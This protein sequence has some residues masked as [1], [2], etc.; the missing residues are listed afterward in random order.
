[1]KKGFTLIE[2]LVVVLIIGILAAIALPQYTRAVE[3]TRV[4]GLFPLVRAIEQAQVRYHLATGSYAKTFDELDI[5]MPAG[6]TKLTDAKIEYNNFLCFL[7]N[8]QSSY[9]SVYCNSIKTKVQI[10]K[11]YNGH[12]ICWAANGDLNAEKICQSI[13]GKSVKDTTSSGQASGYFI[14]KAS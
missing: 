7:T 14:V 12:F 1:M 11:Y 4:T 3:K 6:G 8:A 9:N 2:L 10:E 5:E 13:T